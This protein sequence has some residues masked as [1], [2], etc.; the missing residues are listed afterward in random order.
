M[1]LLATQKVIMSEKVNRMR[2][3]W[4]RI[5]LQVQNFRIRKKE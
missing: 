5:Y 2:R 3:N 4:G 1:A